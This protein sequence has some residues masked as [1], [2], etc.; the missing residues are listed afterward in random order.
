M[1]PISLVVDHSWNLGSNCNSWTGGDAKF[2]EN[3]GTWVYAYHSSGG[4]KNSDDTS[5]GITK[6]DGQRPFTWDYSKAKGGNSVNPLVNSAPAG[7]GTATVSCVPRP[8]SGTATV[9]RSSTSTSTKT[10]DDHGKTYRGHPTYVPTAH[11]ND[12]E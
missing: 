6:H 8:T 5:A 2:T 9:S 1:I 12:S 11:P 7:T 3:S 4:P 10:G